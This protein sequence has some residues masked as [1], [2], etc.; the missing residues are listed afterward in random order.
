MTVDEGQSLLEQR[1][2]THLEDRILGQQLRPGAHIVA[3]TLGD[4]LGVSRVPVREAL[5]NLAGRGLVELHPHRGA[6]VA[7]T[8]EA[9]LTELVEV[10][11][12]LEPWAAFRAATL[13]DEEDLA[14]LDEALATGWD[15]VRR[16]RRDLANRAHHR[17]LQTISR[18]SRHD[19]LIAALTPLHHR[20][21]LAFA[22]LAVRVDPEGW[23]V[24][25]DIRDAIAAR[26]GERAEAITREHLRK[27]N[28]T[29]PASVGRRPPSA[30][31]E[32]PRVD[33]TFRDHVGG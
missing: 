1:V 29:M 27:L 11:L 20:T 14:V 17:F 22:G 16:N 25:Q 28:S 9:D 30:E 31:T 18:M 4:E 24:H 5:R 26:D 23:Q 8:S 15:G 32:R 12:L 6:F 13:H 2:T 3:A 21:L 19:T 7:S 10:R 33:G